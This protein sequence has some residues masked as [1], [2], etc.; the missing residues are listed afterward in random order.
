MRRLALGTSLG[1]LLLVANAA[2]EKGNAPPNVDVAAAGA[3]GGAPA[4]GGTSG[5]A[6]AVGSGAAGASAAGGGG[7]SPSPADAGSPLPA[8]DAGLSDAPLETVAGSAGAPAGS[9]VALNGALHVQGARIVG[10]TG[11]S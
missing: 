11:Q 2:C 10:A 7:S 1:L 6:G 4:S 9:P 5:S 8:P 3:G